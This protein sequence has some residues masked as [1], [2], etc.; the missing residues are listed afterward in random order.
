MNG[1]TN[2]I[3]LIVAMGTGR[4]IG[5]QG[6]I[7]WH[8]PADLAHFK[9]TTLGQPIVMGRKTWDSIGRPLPGRRNIV[10]SR[11]QMEAEGAECFSTVE[12]VLGSCS[13]EEGEIFVIGGGEIYS[14]FLSVAQKIHL[15]EVEGDFVG[16][17][18]FPELPSDEWKEVSR[19]TRLADAKN[20]HTCHF[21]L[22]ERC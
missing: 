11:S 21:L 20:P 19:N 15:T 7:P 9:K 6:K 16:D 13:C 22:L 17:A 10:L 12:E 14:L 4:V 5:N 3:S 1:S 8:L 18:H 2:P